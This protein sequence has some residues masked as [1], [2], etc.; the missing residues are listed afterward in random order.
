MKKYILV[1]TMIVAM[2]IAAGCEEVSVESLKN[3]TPTN[4]PKTEARVDDDTPELDD[5]EKAEEPE[6]KK[7]KET[8]KTDDKDDSVGEGAA[9]GERQNTSSDK[10]TKPEIHS[11]T[12]NKP[13]GNSGNSSNNSSSSSSS[14]H[15]GS[16]K[17]SHT[18]TWVAVTKQVPAYETQPVYK[19]VPV[20][21]NQP[22]YEEEPVFEYLN[23]CNS[24]GAILV[25][26]HS[27]AHV[28]RGEDGSYSTKM[29]QTG[30]KKVQVGT[31]QVQVG[32]KQVQDGTK[33]V[34]VGTKTVTTG[35]KC[36]GCGATK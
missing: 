21:E 23:V 14:N 18:H 36:S 34:Q 16:N 33:Q 32:T 35:Y 11:G 19:T 15:S 3:N 13:N 9:L 27:K 5:K 17:P 25:P 30:T 28:M 6:E 29:V 22:V 26:G 12:N 7:D 10:D 1:L 4:E 24:C 20:Y 2:L 31:K 8:A